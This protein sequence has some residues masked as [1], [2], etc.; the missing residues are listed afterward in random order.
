MAIE[1]IRYAEKNLDPGEKIVYQ[2]HIHWIVLIKP[3]LLIATGLIVMSYSGPINWSALKA[4]P[5]ETFFSNPF[6]LLSPAGA[7]VAL[8]GALFLVKRLLLVITTEITV[9]SRRIIWKTGL[10]WRHTDEMQRMRIEGSGLAG[11]SWLGQLLNYGT[12]RVKGISSHD[13]VLSHA[14]NPKR[15]RHFIA[16]LS[17]QAQ[18]GTR[19]APRQK[20]PPKTKANT[21]PT[22]NSEIDD[23]SED[24]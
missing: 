1:I 5:V 2:T 9:T 8:Q 15:L 6:M 12:V 16:K 21:I 18:G 4:S 17:A 11:Q 23:R 7:S 3:L 24:T 13:L 14:I 22:L 10:I 20:A 19:A